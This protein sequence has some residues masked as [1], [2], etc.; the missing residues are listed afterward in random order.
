MSSSRQVAWSSISDLRSNPRFTAL[1]ERPSIDFA[2]AHDTARRVAPA[3]GSRR[4]GSITMMVLGNP[5][6]PNQPK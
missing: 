5:G 1:D 2:P 3:S 4:P 6:I